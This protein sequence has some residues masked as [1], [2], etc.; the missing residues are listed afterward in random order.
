M[1]LIQIQQWVTLHHQQHTCVSKGYP[2]SCS[3]LKL[4]SAHQTLI[5]YFTTT[6]VT[7]PMALLVTISR[8]VACS[9][10]RPN[11]AGILLAAAPLSL[12]TTW[13]VYI[14]CSY[15]SVFV[16][17]HYILTFSGA[18]KKDSSIIPSLTAVTSTAVPPACTSTEPSANRAILPLEILYSLQ[19]YSISW[20]A[21]TTGMAHVSPT[22]AVTSLWRTDE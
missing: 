4:R 13:G 15:V 19:H 21:A 5:H 14:E 17:H 22:R 1:L 2:I 3:G 16:I 10:R 6:I 7:L 12:Y 9:S 8:T 18:P 11:V 20:T